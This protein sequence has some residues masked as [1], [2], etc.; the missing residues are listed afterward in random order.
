LVTQKRKFAVQSADFCAGTNQ[1]R[2][3]YPCRHVEAQ[4]APRRNSQQPWGGYQFA[5]IIENRAFRETHQKL[6][7]SVLNGRLLTRHGIGNLVDE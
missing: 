1:Q 3:L 2:L 6:L 7:A 5:E 4:D